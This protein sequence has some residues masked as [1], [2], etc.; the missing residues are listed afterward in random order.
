MDRVQKR[1]P[2]VLAGDLVRIGAV[3]DQPLDARD[4]AGP[5]GIGQG[6]EIGAGVYVA[7]EK[8]E[9]GEWKSHGS[10]Q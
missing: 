4:V 2:A 10:L 7:S 9:R 5:S 3:A 1:R 6:S 8:K